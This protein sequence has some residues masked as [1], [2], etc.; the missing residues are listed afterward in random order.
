MTGSPTV[1]LLYPG[2]MGASLGKLLTAAG[3]R[4]VTAV[5][6]RSDQTLQRSREAGIELLACLTDVVRQSSYVFSLVEPSAA[7][8]I[9][10]SYAQSAHLAPPGTLYIDANSVGPETTRAI[11]EIISES[12]CDFVDGAINGA[13]KTLSTG[14]TFFL[15]GPRAG[16]V[17]GLLG[18]VVRV[19][20]LGSE[21]GKASTLK[22]LLG[23][24]T[25]GMCALFLELALLAEERRMFPEMM[26][27]CT[28]IY[29]GIITV[30]DRM[31]PTYARHSGRRSV[32]MQELQRTLENT[33]LEP[34]VIAAVRRL[35]ERLA[36]L[37]MDPSDGANV[38]SLV[39]R[40]MTGGLLAADPASASA[41]PKVA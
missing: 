9:A 26:E 41:E 37:H 17:A 38:A 12:G 35:H 2:E 21:I 40:T 31:L 4:A 16:D 33:E 34:C 27:A 5:T 13:A 1:G 24:L 14:G 3:L 6:G 23:G 19:H 25:K 30:I 29:P 15:S 18:S 28:M 20:V 11:G 22:M 10:R 7:V 39:Q 8:Q 32:E 36:A